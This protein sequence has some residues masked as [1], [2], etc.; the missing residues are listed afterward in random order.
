[1]AAVTKSGYTIRPARKFQPHKIK[2]IIDELVD[3]FLSQSGDET[4]E[5]RLLGAGTGGGRESQ[6]G[7]SGQGQERPLTN[8]DPS[9]ANRLSTHILTGLTKRVNAAVT[10]SKERTNDDSS[11]KSVLKTEED[12]LN[13]ERY[14]FIVQV[15]ASEFRGQGIKLTAKAVWDPETDSLCTT[16]FNMVIKPSARSFHS[17]SNYLIATF[18]F[19]SVNITG[20]LFHSGNCLWH[21]LLL[22]TDPALPSFEF[23]AQ[24]LREVT[25]RSNVRSQS[26]DDN[27]RSLRPGLDDM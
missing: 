16:S 25:Y 13:L 7:T 26:G 5:T 23:A 11:S 22:M 1:M 27:H 19:V 8:Y 15:T 3:Q 12:D 6:A 20:E 24:L 18:R 4:S 17:P 21:L 9:I 14:K 10:A 2:P